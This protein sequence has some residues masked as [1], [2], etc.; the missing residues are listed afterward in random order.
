MG[1][2]IASVGGRPLAV[3]VTRIAPLDAVKLLGEVMQSVAAMHRVTEEQK[4]ARAL[5]EAQLL[6]KLEVIGT[7]R[8]ILT[9][10]LAQ[11]FEERRIL[12][13]QL[14]A[15]LDE[16]TEKNDVKTAAAILTSITE[17]AK[18]SPL[19]EVSELLSVDGAEWRI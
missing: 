10:Y 16:A 8:Q 18:T 7:M 2:N 4:T 1:S 15:S 13:D 9:D 12:F 17:V 14:F 19:A 6:G 3:G 11:S 5:I